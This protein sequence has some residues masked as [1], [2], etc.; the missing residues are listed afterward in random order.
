VYAADAIAIGR[1]VR[2]PSPNRL[3]EFQDAEKALTI[4]SPV[5]DAKEIFQWGER[6][7]QQP[8][9]SVRSLKKH[10]ADF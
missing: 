8:P 7:E 4:V 1:S 5:S 6:S 10:G 3:Q 2:Q 9:D